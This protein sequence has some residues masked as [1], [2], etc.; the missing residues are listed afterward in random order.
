MHIPSPLPCAFAPRC[1]DTRSR[2]I[3]TH[4]LRMASLNARDGRAVWGPYCRGH[5]CQRR[6]DARQPRHAAHT[7]PC[8]M[9]HIEV[10]FMPHSKGCQHSPSAFPVRYA[11]HTTYLTGSGISIILPDP[12]AI[13]CHSCTVRFSHEGPPTILLVSSVWRRVCFATRHAC[14][15]RASQGGCP[16]RH[17][18]HPGGSGYPRGPP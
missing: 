15:V 12:F 17:G 11:I 4:C 7:P 16:R 9:P 8:A 18:P 6:V 10:W 5:L 14:T 13:L 2:E 3:P 1:T